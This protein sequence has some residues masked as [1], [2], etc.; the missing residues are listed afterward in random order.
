MRKLRI[1]ACS[2]PLIDELHSYVLRYGIRGPISRFRDVASDCF[3]SAYY[4]HELA[5]LIKR[6]LLS[7]VRHGFDDSRGR[8]LLR[9]SDPRL[10][11]VGWSVDPTDKLVRHIWPDR[12]VPTPP[13]SP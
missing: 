1:A 11:G 3:D 8:D 6:K 2:A 7:V 5:D 4:R 9:A 10:C 12:V 13:V